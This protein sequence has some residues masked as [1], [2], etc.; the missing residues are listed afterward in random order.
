[1]RE[2]A[3]FLIL[4]IFLIFTL[5]LNFNPAHAWLSGWQYRRAINITNGGSTAL[6]D[7]QVLITLRYSKF[8][9]S[10]KNEK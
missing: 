7:Y 2:N 9:F 10:W 5:L 4:G 1:M 8:N 3:K 6:T